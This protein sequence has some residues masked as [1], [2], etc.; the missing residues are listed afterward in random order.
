[1][2]GGIEQIQPPQI[3]FYQNRGSQAKTKCVF[4]FILTIS[5][6]TAG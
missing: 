6:L 3:D 5:A 4:P 2:H 1:M